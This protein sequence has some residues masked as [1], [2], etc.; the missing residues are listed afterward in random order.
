MKN[1]SLISLVGFFFIGPI[2]VNAGV[3]VSLSVDSVY[4]ATGDLPEAEGLGLLIA[5]L[6]GANFDSFAFNAGD[7][8]ELGSSIGSSFRII[9]RADFS[10]NHALFPGVWSESTGSL[11]LGGG[12]N[13]GDILA[14]VWLP[15][16]NIV[17]TTVSEGSTYGLATYSGWVTPND[18]GSISYQL[19]SDG[20]Y[21]LFEFEAGTTLQLPDNQLRANHVVSA[22][23]EPSAFALIAGAAGLAFVSGRRR[24]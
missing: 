4:T 2:S 6:G 20:G 22:V 19:L 13:A 5:G 16:L 17:S 11:S 7:S 23:P 21:G 12:W 14:F 18:G 15:T 8:I 10:A 9:H 24:R 1:I 3:T